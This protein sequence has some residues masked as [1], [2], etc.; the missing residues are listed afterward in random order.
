M[1]SAKVQTL[2][3]GREAL[4]A[5][6]AIAA[7]VVL[8]LMSQVAA[9]QSFEVI[10]IKQW[11]LTDQGSREGRM[12]ASGL[13]PWDGRMNPNGRFTATAITLKRMI[14]WAY[15]IPMERISGGPPWINS[16][17]YNV[18]AKAADGT[19]RGGEVSVRYE[20]LHLMLQSLLHDQF[21]LKMHRDSKE[22]PVYALRV[23]KNG[24][25]VQK[26]NRDCSSPSTESL[27][28]L[29]HGFT[30]GGP[31]QGIAGQ[32]IT[33]GEL[34]GFLSSQLDRPVID[35]TGFNG[36]FD[37]KFGPWNPYLKV[38][39]EAAGQNTGRRE[40]APVDFNSLP[41][42]FTMLEEQFGLKLEPSR[43]A[44]DTLV[45]DTAEIPADN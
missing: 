37:I 3:L 10:S 1:R 31:R 42:L 28:T 27:E 25:R 15:T 24:P 7:F 32:S 17:R 2:G 19:M 29:C 18:E 20:Q 33:M 35:R 5:C 40:G 43:A 4:V 22:F 45:V 41:T 12:L 36:V 34:A 8:P 13:D 11:K 23:A 14:S 30:G 26:T 39:P 38:V 21:S 9:P 44:L 6:I 16:Q